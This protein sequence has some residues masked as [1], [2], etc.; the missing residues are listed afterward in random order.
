MTEKNITP[1]QQ[2]GLKHVSLLTETQELYL[3]EL[4]DKYQDTIKSAGLHYEPHQLC[5]Y[6]RELANAFHTYYN[7]HQFIV[8]DHNLRDARIILITAT[9]QILKNGLTLLSI[10]VPESM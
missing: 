8:N 4:L 2:N 10:S 9:Q 6:L 7:A 5:H 1:E 3:I